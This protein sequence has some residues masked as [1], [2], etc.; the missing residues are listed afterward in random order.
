MELC[1]RWDTAVVINMCSVPKFYAAMENNCVLYQEMLC[2]TA[3]K[4]GKELLW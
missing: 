2:I 4:T 1:S 3:T